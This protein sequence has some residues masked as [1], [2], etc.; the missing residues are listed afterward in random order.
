MQM[1]QVKLICRLLDL[2]NRKNPRR[3]RA[4]MLSYIF[5]AVSYMCLLDKD[6]CLPSLLPLVLNIIIIIFKYISNNTY[7]Y[8]K[9]M[10]ITYI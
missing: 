5:I 6:T 4:R 2:L 3:M 8:S 1:L 10:T 9:L 7:I